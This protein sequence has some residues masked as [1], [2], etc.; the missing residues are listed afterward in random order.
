MRSILTTVGTSL[1]QN[2][3]RD[4]GQD[5]ASATMLQD[6]VSYTPPEKASAE[7]NSLSRLIR[8]GNRLIFLSSHTKKGRL[9][10]DVLCR[11]YEKLGYVTEC[12]EIMD[13]H[14][15]ES[16]F[17]MRGLRSLVATMVELIK[18]ERDMG[19]KV[20][21]N[22]TGGFKAEIAYATLV[23][24]LFNVKVFYMHEIFRDII[25][26]PSVPVTWNYN[27]LA[28]YE[29]FFA[30]IHQEVPDRF[31]VKKRMPTIP[32]NIRFFL[33]EEEGLYYLSPA[34]E[35]F[36]EAYQEQLT[37]ACDTPLLLSGTARRKYNSMGE[38]QRRLFR[39]TLLKLCH[40][41]MRLGGSGRVKS[42]DCLVYPRGDNIERVFYYERDAKVYVCELACHG[43]DYERLLTK[44]VRRGK[45]RDFEIID[46]HDLG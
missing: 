12:K 33:S 34:G 37:S 15:T 2:A 46:P 9:C 1:L 3:K 22:A 45:Y 40:S 10:A 21:I 13:L 23:G 29:D 7:T 43:G 30:W 32:G 44:G 8:D 38:N 35:A 5:T 27:L 14:Y 17:K 18:R 31:Q 41:N 36:Y 19:C 39:S 16:R 25:E 4:L 26:L 24:L 28:D 20:H 6:Y 42:S 11:H